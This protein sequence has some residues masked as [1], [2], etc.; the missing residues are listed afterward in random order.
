[1]PGQGN[2]KKE[3]NVRKTILA[4]AAVALVV[5][6]TTATAAT[7]ITGKD[8]KDGSITGRDLKDRSVKQADLSRAIR[9]QLQQVGAQGGAP[10][11]PGPKGDAGTVGAKGDT[12]AK[13]DKGEHGDAASTRSAG[14]WGVINRNTIHSPAVE[15]RSGPFDAPVG[16]GSLNLAVADGSEKAA[17][18]NEVDF[19]GD[20]LELDEVGFHVYTTGENNAAPSDNMPSI[21]FEIDPN[22][23]AGKPQNNYTSLVFM[24][25]KTAS[26]AWSGYI[27]ATAT[28]L[29]GLTG[30]AFNGTPC[31][32]NGSR[33][34]FDAMMD[35]LN[36]GGE[37]A[38]ILTVA[39]GKG[40][41]YEFHGAVDGLRINDDVY[42]FEE[43]GV[44]VGKP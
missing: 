36:D 26:N 44:S 1:M 17:Y 33:C 22:L 10:G 4:C 6:T 28:G 2:R 32:I 8:V 41:D 23:A 40:R 38:T 35:Y 27:D 3:R 29:W 19:A 37:A 7:L 12:G 30:G 25:A 16:E 11:T 14:N 13:G 18:G 31:S 39:I 43:H 5:G 15:L 9:A 42:D 34:T 20:P 24:P 21:T